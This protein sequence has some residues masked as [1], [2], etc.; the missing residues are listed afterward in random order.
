[1]S[2]KIYIFDKL[3]LRCRIY[4]DLRISDLSQLSFM[5]H[6]NFWPLYC[7]SFLTIYV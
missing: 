4:V 6:Y 2:H 1:M 7:L 3:L 5:P